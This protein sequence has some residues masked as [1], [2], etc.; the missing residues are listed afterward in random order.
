MIAIAMLNFRITTMVLLFPEFRCKPLERSNRKIN[1]NGRT[2]SRLNHPSSNPLI[3]NK[4]S[5]ITGVPTTQGCEIP[6]S[7]LSAE[8]RIGF[9]YRVVQATARQS[10]RSDCAD[11][12]STSVLASR[13]H[14]YTGRPV[15][16]LLLHKGIS[17][18]W[19]GINMTEWS[20]SL[21][22]VFGQGR[23]LETELVVS[24]TSD[25]RTAF[26]RLRA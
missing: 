1:T 2:G 23:R 11:K 7:T 9:L 21:G 13:S 14:M 6:H 10:L 12:L 19:W 18:C 22:R 5:V 26:G 20:V 15:S 17:R 8:M 24:I 4:S 25:T 16:S 3:F